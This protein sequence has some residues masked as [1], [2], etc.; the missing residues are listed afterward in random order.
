MARN[1]SNTYTTNVNGEQI[2]LL[3][4]FVWLETKMGACPGVVVKVESNIDGLARATVFSYQTKHLH[5]F[6]AA[7]ADVRMHPCDEQSREAALNSARNAYFDALCEHPAWV[8]HF[9][10]SSN[11]EA[12][13]GF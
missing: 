13:I 4:C 6:I 11:W 2:Q 9:E 3:G 5:S 10:R 7:N 1:L 8:E 12:L